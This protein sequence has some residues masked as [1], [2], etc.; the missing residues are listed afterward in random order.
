MS[1]FNS[2]FCLQISTLKVLSYTSTAS[3]GVDC[4]TWLPIPCWDLHPSGNTCPL[5]TPVQFIISWSGREKENSPYMPG[6]KGFQLKSQFTWQLST[7]WKI[8]YPKESEGMIKLQN[9]SLLK[10]D[11]KY[12]LK[13]N[14]SLVKQSCC[15]AAS[16]D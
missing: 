7:I 9:L 11:F 5:S 12:R 3:S 1:F 6:H 2:I 14:F 13:K 16:N 15:A 8:S 10:F 4:W